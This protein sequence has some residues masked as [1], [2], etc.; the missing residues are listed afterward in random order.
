MRMMKLSF[1]L[2]QSC[3]VR[4]VVQVATSVYNHTPYAFQ[5]FLKLTEL[6]VFHD[7]Q[8]FSKEKDMF[9]FTK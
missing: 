8:Q 2:W 6:V 1:V 3:L 7:A 4:A 5:I 9:S